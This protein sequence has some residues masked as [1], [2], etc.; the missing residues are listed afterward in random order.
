MLR[1]MCGL[2]RGD[3]WRCRWLCWRNRRLRGAGV[4]ALQVGETTRETRQR[5]PMAM[6]MARTERLGCHAFA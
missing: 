2:C 1:L 5:S 6:G 3:F 4:A